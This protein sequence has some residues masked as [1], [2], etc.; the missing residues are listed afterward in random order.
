VLGTGDRLADLKAATAGCENVISLGWVNQAVI[1]VVAQRSCAGLLCYRP[2]FDFES[3]LPNKIGE[4][5]AYGL[6]VVSSLRRGPAAAFLLRHSA[7]ITYEFGNAEGLASAV[8][9]A[10]QLWNQRGGKPDRRLQEV[11]AV[12][13]NA[14]RSCSRLVRLMER[15]AVDYRRTS[16][17]VNIQ[18]SN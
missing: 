7:G 4:Y 13:L 6:P 15:V 16:S 9:T 5:L 2:T 11:Q 14:E 18:L 1:E 17:N 10:M 3:G 12:E 8:V